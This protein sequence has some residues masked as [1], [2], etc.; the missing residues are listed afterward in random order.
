MTN[1]NQQSNKEAVSDRQIKK[2]RPKWVIPII[3]ILGIV[4]LGLA[5]WGTYN[6]LKPTPKELPEAE[7]Q[8]TTQQPKDEFA[9]WKTYRNEEYGF[10][11]KYPETFAVEEKESDRILFYYFPLKD[12]EEYRLFI[13]RNEFITEPPSSIED[14][15]GP[16]QELRWYKK[17][18]NMSLQQYLRE[19][20]DFSDLK[21]FQTGS[22]ADEIP[23]FRLGRQPESYWE[24][25][26]P[27][28]SG[29][30][31]CSIFGNSNTIFYF[32]NPRQER[33]LMWFFYEDTVEAQ[34]YKDKYKDIF[35]Q[36]LS[37]FRFLE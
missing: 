9:G 37:T 35:D 31:R 24:K 10:E 13:E 26:G 22:T 3:V 11:F 33:G 1:Q 7:Q 25:F 27:L 14:L 8:P 28:G 29:L 17:E 32:C 19:T 20:M 2:P 23:I 16:E 18:K 5:S 12:I 30:E 36:I 21:F 4:I 15:F 6:L 34:K